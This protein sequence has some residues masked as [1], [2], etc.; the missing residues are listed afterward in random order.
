[1]VKKSCHKEKYRSKNRKNG[2][3]KKQRQQEKTGS[4]K[5]KQAVF[6]SEVW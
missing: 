1:M 3:S 6:H 5:K 4:S 2:S